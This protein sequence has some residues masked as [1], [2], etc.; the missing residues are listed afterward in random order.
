MSHAFGSRLSPRLRNVAVR[1]LT[2]SGLA[3]G[4][5]LAFVSLIAIAQ[6][7]GGLGFDTPSYWLAG[8]H[9]LEGAHLYDADPYSTLA[10]YTYPPIFAQFYVPLALLPE[11]FVAWAWRASG[12]FCLR[13]LTG[14]WTATVVCFAFIPVLTEISI[15]NVTLQLAAVI[16]FAMRDKRGAYLLPWAAMI[17]FGP[18]LIVP[19]L[20]LNKPESRRPLVVGTLVF[21]AACLVSI[22]LSPRDWSDYV[23]MLR[24]QNTTSLSGIQVIHLIPSGGGIDFVA[25]FGLA[26]IVAL[27]AAYWR[28]GWLAYAAASITC[29]VMAWSRFAPLVGLWRFRPAGWPG[30][31][32]AVDQAADG[33][34]PAGA[35]PPAAS[36]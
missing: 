14:S 22:F 17:K 33:T 31:S 10:L 23:N 30:A 4:G 29:P 15:D 16:L 5:A 24:F 12:V 21:L 3:L 8:R 32:Q 2:D 27:L 35:I 11:L 13:Y 19:Y 20:W 25:R 7:Y 34:L 1:V 26:G 28:R 36:S 18:V 6:D 9:V